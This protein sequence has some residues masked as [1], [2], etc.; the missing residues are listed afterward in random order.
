MIRFSSKRVDDAGPGD[1]REPTLE[2]MKPDAG[3]SA[4]CEE[5]TQTPKHYGFKTLA[6]DHRPERPNPGCEIF[7]TIAPPGV[8][9]N[10]IYRFFSLFFRERRRERAG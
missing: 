9:I 4:P 1:R 3:E 6:V 7:V 5:R 2:R 10:R 8:K